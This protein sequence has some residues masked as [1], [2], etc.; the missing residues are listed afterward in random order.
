MSRFGTGTPVFTGGVGGQNFR[1]GHWR[2]DKPS[3]TVAI[4]EG[5]QEQRPDI[6]VVSA[7]ATEQ[8]MREATARNIA[9]RE[10]ALAPRRYRPGGE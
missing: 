5:P 7:R 3:G 1:P 6:P 2:P 8:R 4:P 9:E 10:S